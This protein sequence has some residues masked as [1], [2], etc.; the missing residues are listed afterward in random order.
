MINEN[1]TKDIHRS[2][3]KHFQ[4]VPKIVLE[5]A[6]KD[7]SEDDY[8]EL[9]IDVSKYRPTC[10]EFYYVKVEIDFLIFFTLTNNIYDIHKL[11]GQI[12]TLINNKLIIRNNVNEVIGC[13]SMNESEHINFGPFDDQENLIRYSVITNAQGVLNGSN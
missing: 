4:T 7:T 3:Y 6:I 8:I 5:N 10:P 1:W 2:I 11:T 9:R 12:D 13:F